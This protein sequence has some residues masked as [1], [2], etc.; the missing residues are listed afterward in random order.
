[1]VNEYLMNILFVVLVQY[2]ILDIDTTGT[3][4]FNSICNNL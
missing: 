2:T 4:C 1:M 3:G